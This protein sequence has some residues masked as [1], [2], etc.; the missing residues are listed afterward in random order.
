ME[1]YVI[2][3]DVTCDLSE[4]IREEFGINDYIQGYVQ[5]SDGRDF[6]TTLDWS[7]ISREDYYKALS[8]RRMQVNTAPASPEAFYQAF[9]KYAEAGYDILSVSISSGISST[10]A[11]ATGAAERVRAEYPDCR[12][13][14]LDSFKM[15]G[16]MGL[17]VMYAFEMQRNGSSF[18]E[19]IDWLENNKHRVH[20]MGPIDDL[21]VVARR[22]RITMGKAIMGNFAGVKPMGDCS[23]DG[24]VSVLVKVKGINKALDVT[25]R[26]VD[27]MATDLE[28]QFVLICHTNREA[29]AMKLKEML[30]QQTK[31]KK[32]YVTDSYPA[33]ATNIG[34]GMVGVYFLGE[35]ITEDLSAEK[36]AINALV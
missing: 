23:R 16:A 10:Y 3:P 21:I 17:L 34:A 35:E 7:N 30:E 6:A 13:Y 28:N 36:D 25:V 31:A 19:V 26:Y 27:K 4:Q 11:V 32:V 5:F 12:I 18:Q 22:G 9:K 2:L 24:Y 33:C 14:C 29:Y 1:K 8:N 15:S 20:Q